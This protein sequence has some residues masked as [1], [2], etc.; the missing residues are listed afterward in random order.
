[1]YKAIKDNKIIAISDTDSEFFCLIKDSV[2][3]V[4]N[5]TVLFWGTEVPNWF[6][7]TVKPMFSLETWLEYLSPIKDAFSQ[8]W[9]DALGFA[10]SFWNTV[11]DFIEGVINGTIDGFGKIVAAKDLLT[12]SSSNFNVTHV[13]IS[14]YATG[15]FPQTG[16]LFWAQEA[17]PELVGTM[18]GR[19][20]VASNNEITGITAAINNA[21]NNEI[22]LLRQQN[23]LLQGILAK[24]FG[25]S[26][27]EVFT[28]VRKSAREYT[29]MTGNPAF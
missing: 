27:K 7:N 1:M 16:S 2:E 12:G 19:T 8:V 23:Q 28:S 9:G 17:G 11:S 14:K 3:T 20:A 10:K 22:A 24:E 15:G 5:D 26:S 25:I 29:N 13:D 18:N 21:S 4:W 6:E